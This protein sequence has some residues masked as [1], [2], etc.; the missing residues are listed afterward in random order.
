VLI[1]NRPMYRPRYSSGFGF[2]YFGGYLGRTTLTKY[3]PITARTVNTVAGVRITA[4]HQCHSA[5]KICI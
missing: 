1:P 5:A 4:N 3:P 2:L